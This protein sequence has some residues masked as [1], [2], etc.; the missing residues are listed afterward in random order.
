MDGDSG[1]IKRKRVGK[2][3]KKYQKN[4]DNKKAIETSELFLLQRVRVTAMNG[5]L[6]RKHSIYNNKI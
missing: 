6:L 1:K 2:S 3:R 5:F 4:D